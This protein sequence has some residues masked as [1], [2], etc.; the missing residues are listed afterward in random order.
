M[1]SGEGGGLGKT[2]RDSALILVFEF[3]GTVLLSLLYHNFSVGAGDKAGFLLGIFIL[4]IFS[5]KISGSHYNP[6][7][8]LAFM[9]RR[10]TGRFSRLLGIAYIIFQFIGA[11]C[12]V[13]LGFLF[14]YLSGTLTLA[15]G[16]SS[17]GQGI[18]SEALGTFFL[19][20]LYL[21][22]TEEQTKLSK[23]PAITTLIIASS[24][25]A[26]LLF[27]SPPDLALS[28]LNPAIGVATTIVMTFKNNTDGI[29]YIWIYG[30][31]PFVGSITAV[32]FHELVFKKVQTAI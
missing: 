32:I 29:E 17:I 28:C 3:L 16:A 23:D 6:A 27:T 4:L 14:T 8:T 7:V 19:T 15:N 26:A 13:L 30:L 21:T 25:L 18:V 5:A 1:H 31:F 22:Q 9:L 10:D 12:G 24:Y 2:I 11:F 20:F